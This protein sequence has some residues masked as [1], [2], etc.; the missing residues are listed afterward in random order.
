[1]QHS[2]IPVLKNMHAYSATVQTD[3]RSNHQNTYRLLFIEALS[4]TLTINNSTHTLKGFG[5]ISL[6]PNTSLHIHKDVTESLQLPSEQVRIYACDYE[7]IGENPANDPLLTP[8]LTEQSNP[9]LLE[10]VSTLYDSYKNQFS[11]SVSQRLPIQAQFLTLFADVWWALEQPDSIHFTKPLDGIDQVISYLHTHYNRKI[12]RDDAVF[13]SGLSLRKFTLSFKQRTG[14]TFIEYLNRIRIDK[15]KTIM[16]QSQASLNEVANQVG[17]SD[18]FYLSRKFKQATGMS[19]TVYLGKPLKIASLDHAYTLDLLSLGVTPCVAITD[20]WVNH[21]FQLPQT[22]NSFQPLYW[23]TQHAERLQILQS[24]KPDIILYPLVEAS[25]YR[26]IEQYSDIGLVI[27]IPW[28]GI[29][30]NQ[31]FMHIAQLTGLEKQARSWL[32][33]FEHRAGQIRESLHLALNPQTT[34]AV[35]NVRSDRSLIYG[36]GYMGADLL[37]DILQ[38]TPPQAVKAMRIQGFE[39]PE[40]SLPQLPAYDADHYFVSIENN[41]AARLRAADMMK[42]TE[43]LERTAVKQQ[44]VYPV[45]MTK[46]YGYGPAALDAQL[47]DIVHYLLPN[48]PKK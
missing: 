35:I 1:M 31:H 10:Q 6:P 4:V 36:Y 21:R 42:S 22:S 20:A 26:Q 32:E 27:Q 47:D 17:Y 38:L 19:P 2:G 41:Q 23:Q 5:C 24:V 46:W 25:E 16:L 29:N 11:N 39:H 30:W 3:E 9:F 45:D 15:A 43:W 34:V 28:R 12:Q 33:Y 48:N 14:S 37:Y 18:E 8:M 44:C 13:M 40:F 7:W